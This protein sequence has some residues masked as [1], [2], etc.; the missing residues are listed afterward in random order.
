MNIPQRYQKLS[1]RCSRRLKSSGTW[2]RVDRRRV[3]DVSEELAA[4]VFL[5]VD[6]EWS[7]VKGDTARICKMYVNTYNRNGVIS[8]KKGILGY[9]QDWYGP[10]HHSPPINTIRPFHLR[11]ECTSY[12]RVIL[13]PLVSAAAFKMA[14]SGN[15]QLN[16][17]KIETVRVFGQHEGHLIQIFSSLFLLINIFSCIYLHIYVLNRIPMQYLSLQLGWLKEKKIPWRLGPRSNP[18][19]SSNL[20]K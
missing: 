3:T 6:E 19:I 18:P 15:V 1:Q 14:T 7:A 11:W 16:S 10:S 17:I 5:V 13:L 20:R 12:N 8:Q 2:R 9:S 4:Y